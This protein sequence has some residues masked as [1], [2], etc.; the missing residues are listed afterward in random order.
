M[1]MYAIGSD[2][3]GIDLR[4]EIKAHLEAKGVEVRDFGTFERSGCNYPDIA[5]AVGKSV[6]SGE[7][8]AGVLICG[9]GL[10]MSI[11]ANK[12]AG[13]R[14]ACVSEPFSA[15]MAKQHN[16]AN[17]ICFGARVVGSEVAK[18]IVDEWFGAEFLGGRHQM[19]VDMIS[20]IEKKQLLKAKKASKTK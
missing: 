18:M 4:N 8:E 9:T 13:V 11:A 17:I 3:A 7:C 1:K 12:V 20:E 14:A 16:N 5:E 15:K 10:G 19:R 2:H 6:A